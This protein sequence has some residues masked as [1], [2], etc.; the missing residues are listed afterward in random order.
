MLTKHGPKFMVASAL[1]SDYR[2]GDVDTSRLQY[3]CM[4][5]PPTLEVS[6][7][8]AGRQDYPDSQCGQPSQEPDLRGRMF[9][10]TP[11]GGTN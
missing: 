10:W 5:W 2:L 1:Y 4:M 11:P 6:W 7:A 8:S 3:G 9:L